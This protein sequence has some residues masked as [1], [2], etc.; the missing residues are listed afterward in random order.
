[1]CSGSVIQCEV[2][3]PFTLR[4]FQFEAP[5]WKENFCLD[6]RSMADMPYICASPIRGNLG[7]VGK[8]FILLKY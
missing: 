3:G 5:D 8:E 7:L 6:I 4:C 1:M 2:P